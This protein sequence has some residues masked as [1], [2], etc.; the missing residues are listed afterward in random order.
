MTGRAEPGGL[1]DGDAPLPPSCRILIVGAGM[2]GL[3]LAARLDRAGVE[4]VWVLEAG[5]GREL[6]HHNAALPPDAALRRWLRP[7]T[8]PYF[9][10][11]WTSDTPPHY[12]A[13]S[14][15]R[16]RLG[17]RSL[18]WYGVTLP[19]EDWALAGPWWPERVRL[20]LTSRWRDGPGLYERQQQALASWCGPGGLTGGASAAKTGDFHWLP[21]PRAVRPVPGTADRWYAYS[22]L[23]HWR[24][25]LS[26]APVRTPVGV[27]FRTAVEVLGLTVVDGVCRGATVRDR[28]TGEVLDV[29]ADAVVLAAGTLENSRLAIQ[30]LDSTGRLP[31]RRLAGLADHVV[32]GFFLCLDGEPGGRVLEVLAPGSYYAP[33]LASDRS[34][35]FTAVSVAPGGRVLV[36]FRVTGEQLRSPDSQVWLEPAEGRW[37]VRVRSPLLPEDRDLLVRQRQIAQAVAEEIAAV[38]GCP[39]VRLAFDEYDCPRRTNAFVLPENV[40][41]LPSGTPATWST[42]LGT[43]DHEGGTLP[44]GGLLDDR[45]ELIDIRRLYA[46]GPATF[47][48]LGAANPGL[49]IL[50]LAHRLARMLVDD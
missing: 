8:D 42:Y 7:E 34:N 13:G 37:S 44:L 48:R 50:A 14:G 20:D 6:V 43:E 49:T 25:P 21:T 47:P 46:T 19:I 12:T 28:R 41:T 30:A 45:H 5:E 17:G 24:D 29:R 15:L 9:V 40:G 35:L 39:R 4:D 32:Q 11:H 36:D 31:Q 26:G 10:R 2:A 18:Y 1:A 27:T 23:D 22:P 33:T 16:Q 38:A 3:E